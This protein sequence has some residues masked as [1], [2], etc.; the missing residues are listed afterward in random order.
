[1]ERRGRRKGVRYIKE[2]RDRGITL[3]KRREGLFKLANDLSILTDASVAVCLHDNN[4]KVQFFGAPMVEPI[5]DAFLSE[6]PQTK[7]FVDKQL[8][9]K[10]ASMQRQL[11]QLESEQDEKAK[12]TEKSIQRFNEV[13]EQSEGPAKHVFSKVEDLSLDE[14]RELY[15]ILLV[16]QQDVKQRL[17][18]LRGGNKLQIGGSSASAR[19]EPSCSRLMASHHPFTPLLPGGTSRIP[20]VPPPQ[21]LGSPWS[22]V[23]PLRSPRFPSAELV[24]S[25]QL[26]LAS[27]SQ[28]TVPLSTMH[29]PLAQKP[30]T[31][32]SSAVPLLTQWQMRFG[33]Q[34]SS[35]AQASTLVEQPQQNDSAAPIPTF[36]DNLL[37]ELLA[38]VSDDGI[39]TDA[40]LGS[41]IDANW[42]ADLDAPNGNI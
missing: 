33:E 32:Q 1:M 20:M 9:A 35:E 21:A 36:S 7:P 5:A 18:T 31:N 8:K 38:D 29:A 6:H 3:S 22:H 13:K 4:N 27:L 15:Q 25:Q 12:K 39:A 16:I 24:P 11:V 19:Q 42:F 10:I 17:P 28:N 14:M 40:A 34:P 41:P 26:P 37:S 23:V 30:I 2:N